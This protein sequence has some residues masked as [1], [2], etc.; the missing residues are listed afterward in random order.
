M[1]GALILQEVIQLGALGTRQ[2]ANHL[3]RQQVGHVPVMMIIMVVTLM[4]KMNKAEGRE[5]EEGREEQQRDRKNSSNSGG[6]KCRRSTSH[7]SNQPNACDCCSRHR[8]QQTKKHQSRHR[9]H[10]CC[11][12]RW[13]CYCSLLLFLGLFLQLANADHHQHQHPPLPT[14][15]RHT[16]ST[17]LYYSQGKVLHKAAGVRE[18]VVQLEPAAGA[19][20]GLC[21]THALVGV[22][23]AVSLRHHLGQQRATRERE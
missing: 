16:Q 1:L 19:F 13:F 4:M 3:D 7:I 11:C 5:R 15:H 20:V 14:I 21:H 8:H 9:L 18:H 10:R 22:H 6:R 12:R 23:P 17:T 2:P